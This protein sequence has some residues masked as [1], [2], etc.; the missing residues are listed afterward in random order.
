FAAP[1]VV[2]R[3]GGLAEDRPATVGKP[4]H[5]TPAPGPLP[6]LPRLRG[7]LSVGRSVRA[8]HRGGA[9]GHRRR[10]TPATRRTRRSAA[11]PGAGRA[12]G[13]VLARARR[14]RPWPVPAARRAFAAPRDR[15]NA[16]A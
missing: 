2:G 13:S 6:C 9:H 7:R 3:N 8:S 11:P 5:D 4:I 16:L 14:T 10:D 12:R 1:Q 15:R